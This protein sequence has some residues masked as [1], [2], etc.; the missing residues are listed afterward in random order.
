[1]PVKKVDFQNRIEQI[2][3]NAPPSRFECDGAKRSVLHKP[4]HQTEPIV[5]ENVVSGQKVGPLVEIRLAL[6]INPHTMSAK[7]REVRF[8][9]F[10][11]PDQRRLQGIIEPRITF[12]KLKQTR[13]IAL[14]VA[15][16]IYGYCGLRFDLA[17]RVDFFNL[18]TMESPFGEEAITKTSGNTIDQN[19]YPTG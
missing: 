18:R 10:F 6:L 3:G 15:S 16:A 17:E 13:I 9:A 14:Q 1:M 19:R 11:L 8:C 7:I 2:P 4:V 12:A 5:G